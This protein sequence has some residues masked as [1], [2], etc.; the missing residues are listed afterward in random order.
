MALQRAA[1][2][3]TA[4]IVLATLLV[5][6]LV[7][8][9]LDPAAPADGGVLKRNRSVT[10]EVEAAAGAQ[11]AVEVSLSAE[12]DPD[13]HFAG[14]NAFV[15]NTELAP[16]DETG[17][18]YD[19]TMEAYYFTRPGTYYWHAYR[20]DCAPGDATCAA[21]GPMR[22]FLIPRPLLTRG[23]AVNENHFGPVRVGMTE[24][25]AELAARL[26]LLKRSGGADDDFTCSFLVPEE[27]KK[28]SFMVSGGRIVRSEVWA[29]GIATT[30]GIVVGD[31][32]RKVF[33][34]YG[35]RHIKVERHVYALGGHYLTYSPTKRSTRKIV[36]ETDS[37]GHVFSFRA[38]R[39]PD[40][41]YVEGC[42]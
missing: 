9:E 32:E 39:T 1:A 25:Q 41:L 19:G 18:H 8:A 31:P 24:A 33:R 36:F 20:V 2:M 21:P 14:G 12:V 38:G 40:V 3:A 23:S 13:G 28:V 17:T 7:R 29:R 30:R 16:T 37:R 35:R 22:R 6:G 27:M 4:G 11:V 5:A 42:L 10:F 26:E 34:R 15:G